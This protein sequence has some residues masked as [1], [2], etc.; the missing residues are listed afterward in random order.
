MTFQS[1]ERIIG[2][3]DFN[4][5]AIRGAFREIKEAF[6]GQ[7]RVDGLLFAEG[8]SQMICPLRLFGRASLVACTLVR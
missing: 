7:R 2:G 6:A 4:K 5:A 8:T 3:Q 1:I